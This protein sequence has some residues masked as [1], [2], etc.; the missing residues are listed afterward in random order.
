MHDMNEQDGPSCDEP[1]SP[2]RKES[3][4]LIDG[5]IAME[6]A[7]PVTERLCGL[8]A[9]RALRAS[10]E[11]IKL[12]DEQAAQMFREDY[13]DGFG[14]V[15]AA[16]AAG[17]I[18]GYEAAA[19]KDTQWHTLHELMECG[20]PRACWQDRNWPESEK[21][22]NP[23]TKTSD[24]PMDYRCVACETEEQVRRE[25]YERAAKVAETYGVIGWLVC[26]D[27]LTIAAVHDTQRI[28]ARAI[29]ALGEP[30]TEQASGEQPQR[31]GIYVASRASVPARGSMW[32]ALRSKGHQ[33][34][35]TWIDEDGE[36]QTED[37][38][39]LWERIRKEVTGAEKLVLYAE[40]SD[41]P[42]KGAYVEIGMALAA[43]VPV[44]C[45]LPG[46]ELEARSFRPVGSWIKH[47]LVSI[48]KTVEEALGEQPAGEPASH[49]ITVAERDRD[50]EEWR[51]A[52]RS[53]GCSL[54]LHP[55]GGDQASVGE[56][57]V[58][59]LTEF[60]ADLEAA[61]GDVR[62]LPPEYKVSEPT[63]AV[64]D[65]LCPTC[66][67]WARIE[68]IGPE[69]A[70]HHPECPEVCK[71][72]GKEGGEWRYNRCQNCGE[73]RETLMRFAPSAAAPDP[74]RGKVVLETGITRFCDVWAWNELSLGTKASL[75]AVYDAVL[76]DARQR[77]EEK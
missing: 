59:S 67:N 39:E 74:N 60:T 9:L 52:A 45:V 33:I 62:K 3:L 18:K 76:A 4:E 10:I 50:L 77:Q 48:A 47:P 44:V 12:T 51:K 75:N 8:G 11:G 25:A 15:Q 68:E 63:T 54:T 43:G 31:K 21:N 42:L 34:I 73:M 1:L 22:Y 58:N 5:F 66:G 65:H 55:L 41:F 29:R 64:P 24:P 61:G 32:R 19:A 46:V 37:W 13:P 72:C 28:I 2:V 26:K 40:T 14:L 53:E 30:A 38:G 70:K 20:H 6:R 57:I 16:E 35:S 56:E 69:P 7:K 71:A 23:G 49:G 17:W 27:Q 36:G